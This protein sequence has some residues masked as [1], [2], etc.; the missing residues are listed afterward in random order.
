MSWIR[1]PTRSHAWFHRQGIVSCL[2]AKSL[3]FLPAILPRHTANLIDQE[4]DT[5]AFTRYL[6]DG[7]GKQITL[8][9]TPQALAGASSV[10]VNLK[11]TDAAAPTLYGIEFTAD[12]GIVSVLSSGW[13]FKF[14][15]FSSADQLRTLPISNFHKKKMIDCLAG[16]PP[17]RCVFQLNAM[18][19]EH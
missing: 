6:M 8:A 2:K 7:I 10:E 3:L 14:R 5:P 9:I 17:A 18:P 13:G 11:A 12:H 15:P 4:A 16:P 19:P 1:M